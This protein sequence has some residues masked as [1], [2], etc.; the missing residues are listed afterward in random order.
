MKWPY[1][2]FDSK[3]GTLEAMGEPKAAWGGL[4]DVRGGLNAAGGG[5]AADG[6]EEK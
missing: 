5:Q 4:T 2:L 1:A 6:P 3:L